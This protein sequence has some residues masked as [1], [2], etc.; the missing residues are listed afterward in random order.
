MTKLLPF[1]CHPSTPLRMTIFAALANLLLRQPL[2]VRRLVKNGAD[3]DIRPAQLYICQ[4][5][6]PLSATSPLEDIA[7]SAD[8]LHG[9]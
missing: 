3:E 8:S 6:T 7:T 2:L 4:L 5:I 1:C 9:Q